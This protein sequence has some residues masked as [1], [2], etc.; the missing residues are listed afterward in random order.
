[1]FNNQS[2]IGFFVSANQ[3]QYQSSCG[4]VYAFSSSVTWFPALATCDV[5]SRACHMCRVFARLPLLTCFPAPY[6]LWR[7]F[8]ALG[9]G[10]SYSFY[11][12]FWLVDLTRKPLYCKWWSGVHIFFL[13]GGLKS[14][15]FCFR[16][17]W[18]TWRDLN[19]LIKLVQP[20]NSSRWFQ[21][22]LAYFLETTPYTYLPNAPEFR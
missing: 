16:S 20:L 18:L 1:M 4:L 3:T 12:K 14:F 9:T 22:S 11:F 13:A 5:L 19:V 2:E 7:F 21:V 15:V 6:H 10:L 17:V 8:P